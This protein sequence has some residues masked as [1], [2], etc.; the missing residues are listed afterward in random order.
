MTL[1]P[2]TRRVNQ[3]HD[4]SI[5]GVVKLPEGDREVD[6]TNLSVGGL[7]IKDNYSYKNRKMYKVLFSIPTLKDEIAVNIM[8]RWIERDDNGI[9]GVGGQFIGIKAKEV[10]GLTQY[11]SSLDSEEI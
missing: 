5:P 8:L 6:I 4:V 11:F 7:Y 1:N 3:R 2:S 10:W 9:K